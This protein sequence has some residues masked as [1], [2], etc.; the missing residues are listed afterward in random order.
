M[1]RATQLVLQICGG[2]AGPVC[3]ATGALPPRT[4]VRMRRARAERVLGIGLSS[5]EISA[6]MRGLG[7]A[8]EAIGDDF[9]V[10]PPS[11]AS[12]SRSRKT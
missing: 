4:P 9:V 6:V 10:T 2:Q 11:Y 1:E 8:F 7:F 5:G 12:I 3:E